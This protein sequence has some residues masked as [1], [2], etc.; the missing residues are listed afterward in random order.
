MDQDVAIL[1]ARLNALEARL[2]AMT[3]DDVFDVPVFPPS[4]GGGFSGRVFIGGVQ[5]ATGLGAKQYVRVRVS[6]N[7]AVDHDGP[8]VSGS[9]DEEWYE[10]AYTFGDIRIPRFG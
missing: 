7:T 4:P 1:T 5:V 10:V 6:D 2:N 9:T 3:P 8:P